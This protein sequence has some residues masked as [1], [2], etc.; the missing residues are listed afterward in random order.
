MYLGFGFVLTRLRN[1]FRPGIFE[2][3]N[4]LPANI[5]A[6]RSCLRAARYY[7]SAE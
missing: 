6:D 4:L 5:V 1:L 3:L 7:D 2:T